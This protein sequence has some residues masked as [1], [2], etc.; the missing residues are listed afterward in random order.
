MCVCGSKML[1]IC[2]AFFIKWGDNLK[3]WCAENSE[4]ELC[5]TDKQLTLSSL[6]SARNFFKCTITT[7]EN[8][9]GPRSVS[10]LPDSL[11]P[12][13]TCCFQ[14]RRLFGFSFWFWFFPKPHSA[15][16]QCVL[17]FHAELAIFRRSSSPGWS[18]PLESCSSLR[19]CCC[20]SC[21]RSC[22]LFP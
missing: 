7:V 1:Q 18:F 22:Y 13:F 8:L 2:H 11:F 16:P 14:F 19:S 6:P 3:C 20:C 9:G 12:P 10:Y 21:L 17:R 5:K 4:N 15:A